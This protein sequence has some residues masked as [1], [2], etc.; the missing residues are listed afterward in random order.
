MN[1]NLSYFKRPSL[2]YIYIYI[3]P[4]LSTKPS[5]KFLMA[6]QLKAMC[7]Y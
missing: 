4:N 7:P 1:M 6:I 3:I 5:L 2:I